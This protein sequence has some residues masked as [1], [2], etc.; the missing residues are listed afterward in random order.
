MDVRLEVSKKGDNNDFG[1]VQNPTLGEADF[2]QFM[3]LKSQLVLPAE[4][5][6][7]EENLSPAVIPKLATD[8]DGQL[9][10]SH[11]VIDVVDGAKRKIC[12][13]LLRYCVDKPELLC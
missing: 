8:M 5:L 1:L 3:R 13:T 11:K 12:L 6:A 10:L 9:K 7:R 2:N 4:N